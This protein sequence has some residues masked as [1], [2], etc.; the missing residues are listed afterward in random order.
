MLVESGKQL[1]AQ[2]MILAAIEKQV[3]GTAEATADSSAKMSLGFADLKETLGLALLP[4][5]DALNGYL[6]GFAK[7][8][9]E[10]SRVILILGGVIGGLAA[11]IVAANIAIKAYVAITA[12]IKAATVAWT[13][14]QGALNVALVAN[15]IGLIIIAITALIGIVVL[16]YN[17]VDWFGTSST[18]PSLL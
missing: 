3:G 13:V 15:P 12:I 18:R 16:A 5:F 8:A 7:W 1:E 9:S 10:N 6:A 11:A 2:E 4:A 14:V 17:K